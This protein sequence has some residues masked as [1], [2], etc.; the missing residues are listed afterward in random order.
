M[1]FG[2]SDD[3]KELQERVRDFAQREVAPAGER[4]DREGQCL[5]TQ[6]GLPEP[7]LLRQRPFSSPY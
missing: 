3:Q 2:L 7:N 5:T 6:T 4:L 1:D